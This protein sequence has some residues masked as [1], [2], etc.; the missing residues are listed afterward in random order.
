MV[1]VGPSGSTVAA[2]LT[3]M[4]TRPAR[5]HGRRRLAALLLV[6]EVGGYHA[7]PPGRYALFLQPGAGLVQ[8]CHGA[9]EQDYA[10]A[11]VA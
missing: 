4:S 8:L 3:R 5:E 2:L 9:R 7:D 1:A 11:R 6:G 10:G